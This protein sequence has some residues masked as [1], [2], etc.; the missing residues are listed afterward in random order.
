MLKLKPLI[1]FS[2]KYP[3]LKFHLFILDEEKFQFLDDILEQLVSEPN[4][5]KEDYIAPIVCN[6]KT[7]IEFFGYIYTTKEFLPKDKERLYFRI[8][9]MYLEEKKLIIVDRT[10]PYNP[11]YLISYEGIILN[12]SGGI[13]KDLRNN[14]IKDFLQK[15]VWVVAILTF[16]L[17]SIVQCRTFTMSSKIQDCS[18]AVNICKFS[19]EQTQS[20]KVKKLPKKSYQSSPKSGQ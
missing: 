14:Y 8:A 6:T 2:K 18:C 7:E 13:V 15:T 20:T 9:T 5:Q 17:T 16:L 11:D 3:F 19:K 10:N 4:L 12:K 1:K